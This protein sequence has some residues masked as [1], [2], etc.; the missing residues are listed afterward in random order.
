MITFVR[1]AKTVPGK[2]GEA[3]V[4]AKEIGGVVKRVV[5]KDVVVASAFGGVLGELAW[6][7]QYESA[8]QAEE[9]LSKL[10]ADRDYGTLLKKAET[11]VVPASGHDQLWRHI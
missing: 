6:I 3:I 4:W 1:T 9:S 10:M 11:L 5:G 8:G 2:I 7:I